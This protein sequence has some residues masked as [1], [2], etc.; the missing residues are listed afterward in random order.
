MFDLRGLAI[1]SSEKSFISPSPI[2]RINDF[3]RDEKYLNVRFTPQKVATLKT[4]GN[5][6]IIPIN[7]EIKALPSEV[8][9]YL[10]TNLTG[11][12]YLDFGENTNIDAD[13]AA[14][15]LKDVISLINNTEDVYRI[16]KIT[17]KGLNSLQIAVAKAAATMGMDVQVLDSDELK[18]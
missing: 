16:N 7:E 4:N 6:L 9:T 11:E 1:Q 14:N 3:G 13:K 17:V 12:L 5:S 2:R 8:E 10:K 15:Y 18:F